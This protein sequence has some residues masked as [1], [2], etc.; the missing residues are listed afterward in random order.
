MLGLDF[1]EAGLGYCPIL[2]FNVVI[3][4]PGKARKLD[5]GRAIRQAVRATWGLLWQHLGLCRRLT[6]EHDYGSLGPDRRWLGR[7]GRTHDARHGPQEVLAVSS[8]RNQNVSKDGG[9]PEIQGRRS[10]A[11]LALPRRLAPTLSEQRSDDT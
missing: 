1:D 7:V 2:R 8:S 5:V 10:L 6:A 4:T 3:R 11:P 9:P